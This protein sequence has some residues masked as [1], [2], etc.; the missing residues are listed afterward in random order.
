MAK[1]MVM[2]RPLD[3]M[4]FNVM[5]N[6]KE[7]DINPI[8]E[9]YN[10]SKEILRDILWEELNIDGMDLRTANTAVDFLI[11]CSE[12]KYDL[13]KTI[14]EEIRKNILMA[15]VFYTNIAPYAVCT[16]DYRG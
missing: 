8:L 4:I 7:E 6:T 9:Q 12:K 2:L 10:T 16:G 13:R 1:K 15:G 5:F 3:K 11:D 14:R